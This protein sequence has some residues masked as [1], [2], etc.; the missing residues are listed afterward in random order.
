MRTVL[1]QGEVKWIRL[2][3]IVG[4]ARSLEPPLFV[5]TEYLSH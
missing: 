3:R 4:L 2:K 1:V 5:A